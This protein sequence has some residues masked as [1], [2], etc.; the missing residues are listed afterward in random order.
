MFGFGRRKKKKAEKALKAAQSSNST[1]VV[2][3]ESLGTTSEPVQNIPQFEEVF[4]I[5]SSV[6]DSDPM[7]GAFDVKVDET[8]LKSVSLALCQG[9]REY[10]EKSKSNPSDQD[11]SLRELGTYLEKMNVYPVGYTQWSHSES[12]GIA[13]RVMFN[14]RS[15][16]ALIGPIHAMARATTKFPAKVSELVE[17]ASA[18]GHSAYVLGIDGLAY[19]AF[20]V[21]HSLRE[22]K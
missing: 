16:T 1:S 2:T 19:G 11:K 15:R 17:G 7:D 13:A 9:L 18:R 3:G 4:E 12:Q 21:T 5:I 8:S 14:G 10:L 20:E 22:V 6:F